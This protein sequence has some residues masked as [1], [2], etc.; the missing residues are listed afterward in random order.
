MNTCGKAPTGWKCSRLLGHEGPCAAYPDTERPPAL[1]GPTAEGCRV[2]GAPILADTEDWPAPLCLTHAPTAVLDMLE[3]Q[4]DELT[5][6]EFSC[7]ACGSAYTHQ[8]VIHVRI[9]DRGREDGPGH[10]YS[11]GMATPLEEALIQRTA[12][13]ADWI[14]KG[15]RDEVA[16]VLTCEQCPALTEVL[17]W[18]HKGQ[19]FQA[20][21]LVST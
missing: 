6:V 20:L 7:A 9:R 14:W 12:L 21:R 17:I 15:R 11:I 13:S 19:T 18:Q 8:D 10:Q 4:G 3:L 2:C 16:I 5:Q 1:P